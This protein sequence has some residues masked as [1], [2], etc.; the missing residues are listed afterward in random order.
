MTIGW[1][2]VVIA[3]LYLLHRYRLLG[4]TIRWSALTAVAVAVCAAAWASWDHFSEESKE[5]KSRMEYAKS[6]ECFSPYGGTLRPLDQVGPPWCQ[7][8]ESIHVRGTPVNEWEI[9]SMTP[10]VPSGDYYAIN[11]E[12]KDG[13]IYSISP[14]RLCIDSTGI[15]RCFVSPTQNRIYGLDSKAQ[16][17]H[18]PRGGGRLIL[19]TAE[20]Y[21]A[22]SEFT[23]ISLLANRG[24][25]L[26]NLLPE[27]TDP[28]YY[29]VLLLP[30]VSAM[31]VLVT[32]TYDWADDESHADPHSYKIAI[33]TYN[34]QT[35][36]YFKLDHLW[37]ARKY[38]GDE[39]VLMLE[40]ANVL[41]ALKK[42]EK[43]ERSRHVVVR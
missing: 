2:I 37:S 15:Q 29:Q 21:S 23:F 14:A 41:L 43:E 17:V 5:N 20:D 10:T 8:Y 33:Y 30:D 1:A 19:F 34:Q 7:P 16:E 32:A 4:R 12:Q 39:D 24:G 36:A 9:V 28:T 38:S 40:K 11:G 25:Q 22:D 6:N 13:D 42:A 26:E 3:I 18:L 27:I 35:E 31:P